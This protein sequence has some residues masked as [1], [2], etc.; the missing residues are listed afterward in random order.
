[1]TARRALLAILA[2]RLVLGLI[3]VAQLPLWQTHEQDYYNVLRFWKVHGRLPTREDYPPEEDP[4]LRQATQPPLYFWLAYPLVALL[5]D[6][7]PVPPGNHPPLLCVGD[8]EPSL[9]RTITTRAY[10]LPLSGTVTAAY[11]LR[12]LGLA[13]ALA[14]AA[15]T[16][17]AGRVLFP[18]R[19]AIALVGA[20]LLAFEPTMFEVVINNDTLLLLTGALNLYCAARLLMA[21]TDKGAREDRQAGRSVALWTVL[22]LAGGLLAVLTK[23]TGWAVLG[24]DLLM[25]LIVI[26]RAAL[27]GMGRRRL[28]IALAGMGVLLLIVLG[29][30]LLNLAQYGSVWGRYDW[31]REWAARALQ[32]LKLSWQVLGDILNDTLGSYLGPL[33][34]LNP[35]A[36]FVRLY[37]LAAGLGLAAGLWGLVRAGV[38]RN[39]ADLRA[40]ALMGGLMLVVIVVVV[41]RNLL[42]LSGVYLSN[43]LIYA[44]LRYY[45]PGLPA[46]ALWIGAGF[47]ALL[48]A[49]ARLNRQDTPTGAP[50]KGRSAGLSL[51]SLA[52]LTPLNPLG[53]GLA[54]AW[55][56]VIVLG[57]IVDP[58]AQAMRQVAI[59]P[60]AFAQIEGVQRVEAE[61]AGVP[62]VL[63]YTVQERPDEGYADLTL[64]AAA[65]EPVDV[66]Y[67]AQVEMVGVDGQTVN[68]C[69]FLP[70]R[71]L[72]PTPRWEP[73]QVV[74]IHKALPNCA[75][76]TGPLNLRLRWVGAAPDGTP[77]PSLDLPDVVSLGAVEAFAASARS[78]PANL[79]TFGGEY[80]ITRYAASPT[81]R[82]G[83]TY[84]PSINWLALAPQR[85]DRRFFQYTHVETGATYRSEGRIRPIE[86][87]Y[88]YLPGEII[89]FDESNMLFPPDAP[90]G[91]YIVS[92]GVFDTAGNLLPARDPSGQPTPD[93]LLV[94]GEVTLESGD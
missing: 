56:L 51:S 67:A 26:G 13:F 16:Y 82:F 55:L 24:F 69:R 19:P 77:D 41:F 21:L 83:E 10:N 74:V 9:T 79:G 36:A 68:A 80:Q 62:Q 38:R 50:G 15:L 40:F 25:V 64:Y 61:T 29:I 66:N 58:A 31:L 86:P 3:G 12:I 91:R 18:R 59:S 39:G 78:C 87:L 5:D 1:M 65:P 93:G 81:A 32:D 7:E 94:L 49:G 54:A 37:A 4:D 52:A 8:A 60:E 85:A 70:A 76:P 84:L 2:V 48:P 71:G 57:L 73:G 45:A 75:G 6:G 42:L 43:I 34:Q 30:G 88:T 53:V 11:G 28:L 20:A 72:Y 27:H 46:A 33:N 63:G 35:R 92:L 22:L 89:Y 14:A 47:A 90:T 17:A 44:P 23:I